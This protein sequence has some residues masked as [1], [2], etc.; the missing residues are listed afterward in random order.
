MNRP[1]AGTPLAARRGGAVA[2]VD[3]GRTDQLL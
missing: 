3:S 1:F 2:E